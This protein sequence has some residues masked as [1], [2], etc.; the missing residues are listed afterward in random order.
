MRICSLASPLLSS[1]PRRGAVQQV[2]SLRLLAQLLGIPRPI[3]LT[4]GA[5]VRTLL[6]LLDQRNGP[7]PAP[8]L[9]PNQYL[10]GTGA[11]GGA[12]PGHRVTL[13]VL[14]RRL[15]PQLELHPPV[16]GRHVPS[17]LVDLPK[18]PHLRAPLPKLIHLLPPLKK[19]QPVPNQ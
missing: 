14:N 9:L 12:S 10:A 19:P 3:S 13:V 17:H 2:L 15:C 16:T 1:L 6:P 18:S 11:E 5:Q 4:A 8:L 7:A